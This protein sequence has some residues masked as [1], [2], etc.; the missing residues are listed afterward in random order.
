MQATVETVKPRQRTF[1]E[2]ARRAQIVQGAIAAIAEVGYH[3]ASFTRIAER[4]GLSSTSRISYHF[5][6]RDDLIGEVVREVL[7]T[8]GGF[9][10]ERMA[11]AADP[12]DALDIYIHATVAFIAGHRQEMRALLEIFLAGG[13]RYDA[14]AESHVV[15]P[16]EE[17]LRQG[18]R[19]GQFRPFDTTVMATLIQR[20]VDGLPFMLAANPDLDTDSFANE[21]A[22]TF[23]LATRS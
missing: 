10:G 22:T 17:I 23:E 16:L 15:S 19:D 14:A 20:A 9:V 21:V 5:A 11:V 2:T 18:Q 8:I 4:A 6:G 7:S 12:A 13:F 3:K 1:I